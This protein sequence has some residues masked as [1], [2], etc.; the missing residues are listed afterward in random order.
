MIKKILIFTF[1]TL[2]LVYILALSFWLSL[3]NET[4]TS[5]LEFKINSYV[6]KNYTV[7]VKNAS[8]HFHS[9]RV[10][11]ILVKENKKNIDLFKIQSAEVGINMINILIFQE[12]PFR[13]ELYQGAIKGSFKILPN[14]SVSFLGE[15]IQPNRNVP[16]RKTKIITSKPSLSFKGQFD[17][18]NPIGGSINISM[19]QLSLAGQKEIT[20]IPFDLPETRLDSIDANIVIKKSNL[21]ISA[22]STGDVS[23]KLNGTIRQNWHRIVNSKLDLKVKV[24]MT[25]SYQKKLGFIHGIL[26]SYMNKSGQISIKIIGNPRYPRIEK[27]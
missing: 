12:I 1:T 25:Q 6:P 16:L 7:L 9:F 26:K 20:H 4:I 24:A 2:I 18:L 22:N 8:T 13:L 10:N 21:N 3:S 17:K 23:V 19:N 11:Q 14:Y 27:L 5:W 15:E